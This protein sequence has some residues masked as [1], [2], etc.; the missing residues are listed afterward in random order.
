MKTINKIYR[1]SRDEEDKSE[2][3]VENAHQKVEELR[4]S[5]EEA[6]IVEEKEL[7]ELR[8]KKKWRKTVQKRALFLAADAMKEDNSDLGKYSYFEKQKSKCLFRK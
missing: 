5:L 3:R 8:E 7:D 6:E 4:K 2:T 1:D